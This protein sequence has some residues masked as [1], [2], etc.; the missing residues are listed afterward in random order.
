MQ[1]ARVKA[2]PAFRP[3]SVKGNEMNRELLERAMRAPRFVPHD[4]PYADF[5]VVINPSTRIHERLLA[6]GAT[7]R[8]CAGATVYSWGLPSSRSMVLGHGIVDGKYIVGPA[9]ISGTPRKISLGPCIAIS[10]DKAVEV[11]TDDFGSQVVY[12]GDDLVTNRIQL[13]AAVRDEVDVEAMLTVAHANNMFCQQYNVFTTPVRGVRMSHPGDR[14]RIDGSIAVENTS[15]FDI[16]YDHE[17]EVGEYHQLIDLGAQEVIANVE[18]ILDSGYEIVSDVTGGQD[19]RVLFAALV[20]AGRVKDVEF[21][22]KQASAGAAN[23]VRTSSEGRALVLANLDVDIATSLVGEYGGRFNDGGRHGGAASAPLYRYTDIIQNVERRRSQSFGQ[24]HFIDASVLRTS[25]VVSESPRIR[26]MGGGGELYR[27][28]YQSFFGVADQSGAF[29][30]GAMRAAL[31]KSRNPD[32]KW[33]GVW[34]EV[35]ARLFETFEELPGSSIHHKIDNH[36]FYFRNRFHFGVTQSSPSA[37]INV[38][39]ILSPSLLKAARMLPQAEKSTGRVLFDV[40]QALVERIAYH[41][42]DKFTYSSLLASSYHRKGVYDGLPIETNPRRDLLETPVRTTVRT[43]TRH[44][45]APA[46]DLVGFAKA[47][48]EVSLRMIADDA[49]SG[50]APRISR[51]F[52]P[53]FFGS[54]YLLPT[55]ALSWHSRIQGYSDVLAVTS[56]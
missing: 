47:A 41:P 17:L 14:F 27:D 52:E 9:S 8:Y 19:S 26:M 36:Y 5:I 53:S 34:P 44:P 3:P 12:Y 7:V 55:R 13:A 56:S 11:V 40:T 24:Y 29:D 16:D 37:G 43:P 20:A 6:W 39:P 23:M 18:A 10:V 28:Y 38:N 2:E 32:I 15:S 31:V 50:L 30:E 51:M 22:T 21:N 49:K 25:W 42:Y 1:L 45:K 33:D 48:N 46:L 4:A 35:E 54:A